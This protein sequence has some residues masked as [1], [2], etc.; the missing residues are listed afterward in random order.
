MPDGDPALCVCC[1]RV[2]PI[3][4]PRCTGS[5]E[6]QAGGEG[7]PLAFEQTKKTKPG[8]FASKMVRALFRSV[9]RGNSIQDAPSC[10]AASQQR[11]D[12]VPGWVLQDPCLP[13]QDP[14]LPHLL[15]AA[16]SIGFCANPDFKIRCGTLPWQ[17]QVRP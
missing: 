7:L 17:T 4:H 15:A 13:L 9:V 6:V 3:L 11:V 14:C 10:K 1:T 8:S 16:E 2:A 12:N 5:R